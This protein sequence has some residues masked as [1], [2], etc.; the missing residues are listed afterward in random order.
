MRYPVSNAA[1]INPPTARVR[2]SGMVERLMQCALA[3]IGALAHPH[4]AVL[5]LLDSRKVHVL[6]LAAGL[7]IGFG[8]FDAVAFDAVDGADMLAVRALDLHVLLDL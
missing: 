7:R 8:Q 6:V 2:E 5:D 1:P 4:A 3:R